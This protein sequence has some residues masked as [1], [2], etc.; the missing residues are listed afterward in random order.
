[1]F[2][3]AVAYANPANVQLP[4][5]TLLVDVTHPPLFT[6]GPIVLGNPP[7]LLIS[8]V[9][10]DPL[11][12]GRAFSMQGYQFDHGTIRLYNGVDVVVGH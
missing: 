5:G 6:L 1:M 12:C 2:A 9:S 7:N 11:L 8:Q 4:F 10:D 3:G